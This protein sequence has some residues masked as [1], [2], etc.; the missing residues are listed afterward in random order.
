VVEKSKAFY[1]KNNKANSEKNLFQ[2]KLDKFLKA[3]EK[4]S[5]YE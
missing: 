1:N 2:P 5:A 3:K 4:V